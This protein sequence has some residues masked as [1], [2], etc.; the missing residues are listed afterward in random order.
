[1]GRIS[2][3]LP[4]LYFS[5]NNNLEKFVNALD[6]EVDLIEKKIKEIPE[7]INVDTCP[8]DKLP[9]L[10]ALTGSPLVGEDSILRRRQ[11]RN[12]P[13]L[14]KLK[15][16]QK[17]LDLY[18]NSIGAE[19]HKIKT[20]FRDAE[21]NYVED[22]P[23]GEPFL[24]DDGLWY[25]IRTHYFGI[26]LTLDNHEY[27]RWQDWN[28]DIIERMALWM[29]EFKP[30]HAELLKW[31]NL[32]YEA[33]RQNIFFGAAVF[34]SPYHKILPAAPIDN[35]SKLFLSFNTGLFNSKIQ[36]IKSAVNDAAQANVNLYSGAGLF[37]SNFYTIRTLDR[38]SDY[39]VNF[40]LPLFIKLIKD[41][42]DKYFHIRSGNMAQF[43]DMILTDGGRSL[44]AKALQG[45]K[46]VFTRAV[47]GDGIVEGY[48]AIPNWQIDRE[49]YLAFMN[50]ITAMTDIVHPIREMEIRGIF[51]PPQIGTATI[52]TILTNAG[53]DLG[54]F[55]N[56]IGLFAKDPDTDDE[57]LYGYCSA[58]NKGDFMPGQG[59]SNAV[60]YYFDLVVTIGQAEN[61]TA[62]F[63]EDPASVTLPEMDIRVDDILR[64]IQSNKEILQYQID[65]L[66]EISIKK[67]LDE[68]EAKN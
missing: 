14:L 46:L 54:F 58:G 61:V 60:K 7:L 2:D 47:A 28:E 26:E 5:G 42:I 4:Q 52:K 30:F 45:K 43:N 1:M 63:S 51:T 36:N 48:E 56:E 57:V 21:G 53:Y 24:G 33:S 11:I 16:T 39:G 49:A 41:L 15:G 59:N 37:T 13:H 19:Q 20:Y 25:N 8:D 44:I 66:A 62:I 64:Y 65:K 55:F 31:E 12:W 23:E 40:G 9:Y 67:S 35:N 68:I 17:S 22:K 29:K 32:V 38:P 6:V 34:L 50:K 18:L 27:L 3:T 10:A